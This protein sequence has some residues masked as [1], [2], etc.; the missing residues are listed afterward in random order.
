LEFD[1]YII[2]KTHPTHMFCIY[3]GV[4]AHIHPL[5]SKM[6]LIIEN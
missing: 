2:I 3:P 4:S 5:M 6:R 1:Y